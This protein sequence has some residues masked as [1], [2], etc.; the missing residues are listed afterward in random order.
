MPRL[1]TLEEAQALLPRVQ[2]LV[3]RGRKQIQDY[4]AAKQQL[5][6]T[7]QTVRGNGHRAD[8]LQQAQLATTRALR[9]VQQTAEELH[10]LG[11]EVRDLEM[12]LIDFRSQREGRE[13]YLCWCVG[14]ETISYWHELDAGFGRRQPLD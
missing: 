9:Q 13:I 5:A 11:C 7:V 8:T 14:E 4:V 12:G 6:A 3:A 1:F 2:G 10:A